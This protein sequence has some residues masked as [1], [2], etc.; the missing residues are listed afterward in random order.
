VAGKNLALTFD[1]QFIDSPAI[2][3]TE[4]SIWMFN[5]RARVT[6]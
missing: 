6:Y 2:N 3:P 4:N 5:L 1:V